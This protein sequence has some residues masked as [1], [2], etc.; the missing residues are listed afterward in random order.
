[1][2]SVTIGWILFLFIS[3]A[4]AGTFVETFDNPDLEDWQE[5]IAFDVNIAPGSWKVLN[6]ELEATIKDRVGPRVPQLLI[7]EDDTWEDYEIELKVKPLESHG[8]GL[9]V[10]AARITEKWGLLCT[11]GVLSPEHGSN[12]H[13]FGGRV[14]GKL[15]NAFGRK[16]NPP[17]KLKEWS[18]LKLSVNEAKM[19]FWVNGKKALESQLLSHFEGGVGFGL[20]NYTARFDNIIISGDSIPDKGNLSVSP[21]LKLATTWGNLK[22]F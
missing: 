2:K 5:L 9:F 13:C 20:A 7:I 18:T 3:P 21:R 8:P 22:D 17:L 16:E 10:I 4:W 1:M 14:P 19:T 6:G 11:I 15:F 12:V